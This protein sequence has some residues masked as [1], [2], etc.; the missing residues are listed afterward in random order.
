MITDATDKELYFIK[1]PVSFWN[2]DMVMHFF[3]EENGY[4]YIV[5]YEQL[6]FLTINKK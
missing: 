4:E 1:L 5:L 3:E 6:L 2:K